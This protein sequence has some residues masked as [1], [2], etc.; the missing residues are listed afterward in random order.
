MAGAFLKKTVSIFLRENG[1]KMF[2]M[3]DKCGIMR[4]TREEKI[5][6]LEN[7]M[8]IYTRAVFEK[9]VADLKQV[10]RTTAVCVQSLYI[11]YLFLAILFSK[12][13]L[14]ANVFLCIASVAHLIFFLKTQEKKDKKEKDMYKLNERAYRYIKISV[15]AVTLV[16]LVY[17]FYIAQ[18]QSSF[19]Q[20]AYMVILAAIWLFQLLIEL[21]RWALEKRMD[22]ILDGVK[23]DFEAFLKTSDLLK[24][25]KGDEDFAW[26]SEMEEKRAYYDELVTRFKLRKKQQKKEKIKLIKLKKLQRKRNKI[27]DAIAQLNQSE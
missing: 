8:F 2:T 22:M 17:G 27:N 21:V 15:G 19:M 23:F 1:R 3:K 25:M 13:F 14:F 4:A 24:K 7:A 9:I 12:G 5:K 11:V 20:N 18:E 16:S 26:G 6:S 10:V